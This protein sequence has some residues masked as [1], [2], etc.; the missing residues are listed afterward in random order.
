MQTLKTL[1]EM[2]EETPTLLSFVTASEPFNTEYL[3]KTIID[4][5]GQLV[6]L[7]QSADVFAARGELWFNVNSFL[8]EH[9]AKVVAA[10]Y[11]P[12]E[13]TDRYEE[14]SRTEERSQADSRTDTN[15]GNDTVTETREDVL[16]MTGSDITE[17][18]GDTSKT[19]SST[20][21]NSIAGFDSID[22]SPANKTEMSSTETTEETNTDS[23]ELDRTDSRDI[24][25]SV[26]T[27]HGH[28]ITSASEGTDEGTIT[29]ENHI[30]G[31]IGVTTNQQM[32]EAEL[33][34]LSTF[35][36]YTFIASQF[37]HDMFI[38]IYGGWDFGN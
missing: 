34:M 23:R 24:N 33:A 25:G 13:N 20:T 21:E 26:T 4:Q 2:L 8:F 30:H 9:A 22:Y 31:N 14:K 1:N 6:P 7:Y 17:S 3:K 35:R 36:P 19:G 32:I 38:C 27:A 29:E 18:T 28:I 16:T 37:E 5:C 11:S 15:S 12:I 10:N